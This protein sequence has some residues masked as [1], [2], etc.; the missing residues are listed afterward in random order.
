[1]NE[2]Y[3]TL[4]S[5]NSVHVRMVFPDNK[6]KADGLRFKACP[7]VGV[8]VHADLLA[9]QGTGK[10]GRIAFP[11]SPFKPASAGGVIFLDKGDTALGSLRNIRPRSHTVYQS[12]NGG[13]PTKEEGVY[14]AEALAITGEREFNEEIV[15]VTK[16]GALIVNKH[17]TRGYAQ[18]RAKMAGLEFG[19]RIVQVEPQYVTVGDTLTVEDQ[20]GSPIYRTNDWNVEWMLEQTSSLNCVKLVVYDLP[21]DEVF[22]LDLEGKESPYERFNLPVVLLKREQVDGERFGAVLEDYVA[23]NADLSSGKAEFRR[24]QMPE[25][26][27][28]PDRTPTKGMVYAPED[29]L[30]KAICSMGWKTRTDRGTLDHWLEVELWKEGKMLEQQTCVLTQKD[31]PLDALLCPEASVDTTRMQGWVPRWLEERP[32]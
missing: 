8:Q 22:P 16:D 17:D 20:S 10:E 18:H 19:D 4:R 26:C 11:H 23:W 13:F 3:A 29:G 31:V 15:L 25:P 30:S 9:K 2:A 32:Y 28:G 14:S 21:S 5:D 1:M 27:E 7:D 12:W 6:V 24:Y